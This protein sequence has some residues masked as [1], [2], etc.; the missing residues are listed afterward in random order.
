MSD[1]WFDTVIDL[2]LHGGDPQEVLAG[3]I[4]HD[5]KE[6]WYC[7]ALKTLLQAQADPGTGPGKLLKFLWD[8]GYP[9]HDILH[10]AM[11]YETLLKAMTIGSA[12]SAVLE[13]DEPLTEDEISAE[14]GRLIHGVEDYL[15]AH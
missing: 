5:T 11:L 12:I 13:A 10:A 8:L 9:L 4:I 14:A 2:V 1:E 15:K 7:E 6:Q 3:V